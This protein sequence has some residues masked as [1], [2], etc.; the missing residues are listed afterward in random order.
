MAIP[1]GFDAPNEPAPLHRPSG[2]P[3]AVAVLWRG[4]RLIAAASIGGLI[5]GV[6]WASLFARKY[7]V[8]ASFVVQSRREVAGLSG[9]AA[10]FGV[11]L[12]TGDAA[13]SPQFY[14]DLVGTSALLVQLSACPVGERGRSTQRPLAEVVMPKVQ[15]PEARQERMI[16]WLRQRLIASANTRSGVVSVRFGH[17]DPVVAYGVLDCALRLVDDYNKRI[18]RSNAS[19]ERRFAETRVE[20]AA[21]SLRRAENNLQRFL[22]RNRADVSYSPPLQ[23]EKDRLQRRQQERQ[24]VASALKQM[25]EQARLEEVRDTPVISV[26]EPPRL[27]ALPDAGTRS[28]LGLVAGIAGFVLSCLWV[29]FAEARPRLRA[30]LKGMRKGPA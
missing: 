21:E 27:P 29:L 20:E 25:L 16:R 10:Q 8:T 2:I 17:R 7:T 1:D 5:L 15:P 12:P 13:Q 23:F 22:E 24:E 6:V 4:K 26:V 3:P 11:Q 9:I 30:V 19:A 18:R 14:S 28:R